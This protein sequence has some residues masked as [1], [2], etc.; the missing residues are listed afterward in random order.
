MTG[1]TLRQ[2]ILWSVALMARIACAQEVAAQAPSEAQRCEVRDFQLQGRYEGPCLKGRAHGLGKVTPTA[3]DQ[4]SYEGE[5]R[6]GFNHGQGRKVFPNGDVY[7]GQWVDGLRSGSGVLTFGSG[8]PWYGDRYEGQWLEDMRHG[9]GKY[10]WVFGD[11]Y[12][13]NW[14]K[15]EIASKPTPGQLHRTRYL[16]VLLPRLKA[17]TGLICS[18]L[19]PGASPSFPIKAELLEL[20][21]DRARVRILQENKQPEWQFSAPRWEP[22]LY[23][24]P[25]PDPKPGN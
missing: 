22:A 24:L 18:T 12:Q 4:G 16:K 9:Y 21:E 25:C 20:M 13:G 17:H 10:T 8:S 14:E 6:F 19:S 7:E 23:W 5:F 1:I 3:P 15:N 2:A 11:V